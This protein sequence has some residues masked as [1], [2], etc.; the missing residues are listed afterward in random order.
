MDRSN[1]II[2]S[3][4]IRVRDSVAQ[5]NA[6]NLDLFSSPS[7][8]P[9]ADCVLVIGG[10]HIHA[11]KAYLAIHSKVFKEMFENKSQ[12]EYELTELNHFDFMELLAVIYPSYSPI[13][14]ENVENLLKLAKRFEMVS[15]IN[16]CETFLKFDSDLPLGRKLVLAQSYYLIDLKHACAELCLCAADV[17]NMGEDYALLDPDTKCLLL[18]SLLKADKKPT[19]G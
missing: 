7:K 9:A 4:D 16:Q 19:T 15:V 17:K 3:V 5:R 13:T 6:K 11:S 2:V 1:V 18:K 8:F 14:D 12:K 10:E